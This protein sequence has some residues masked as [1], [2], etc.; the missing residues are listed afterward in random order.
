MTMLVQ[1]VLINSGLNNDDCKSD[2]DRENRA[3]I[4][5]HACLDLSS[6]FK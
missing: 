5:M 6:L 2:G 4:T 1:I 3:A